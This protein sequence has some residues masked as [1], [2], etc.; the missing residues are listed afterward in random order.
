MS[1]RK[2]LRPQLMCWW[3][4]WVLEK[5]SP[6]FLIT[7]ANNKAPKC[8]AIKPTS[9]HYQ[10]KWRVDS[11]G[12]PLKHIFRYCW[13]FCAACG[14]VLIHPCH[15]SLQAS[16]LVVVPS[17]QGGHLYRPPLGC[18]PTAVQA[19]GWSTPKFNWAPGIAEE[20]RLNITVNSTYSPLKSK[21]HRITRLLKAG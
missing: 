7:S 10:F 20:K 2:E 6:I 5:S 16:E 3:L 19:W 4:Q 17:L 13:L 1:G 12:Q 14:N 15:L 8:Y 18:R 9:E 21:E 11:R